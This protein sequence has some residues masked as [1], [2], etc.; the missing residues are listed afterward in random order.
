MAK[1]M[2]PLIPLLGLG[3]IAALL[4]S[5]KS[6]AAEVPPPA[7]P[8]TPPPA[9]SVGTLFSKNGHTWK[10]IPLS[11]GQTDVFAP[12]GSWGP[13]GEL[14]VLRFK[15]GS[16]RT[17]TGKAD[18]VPKATFDAA[19]KDLGVKIASA[20]PTV[21]TPP[22][23]P[24]M[25]VA[26][27]QEMIALGLELGVDSNGVVRGPVK[28]SGVQHATEL[29]SRLEQAGYPEAA[30]VVR[31]QATD[32]AKMV[33]LA[34]PAV[35]LPGVPPEIQAA[36]ARALQLERDPAKLE[37]LK[38]SLKTLPASA[39]R[40]MLIG[41]LDAM[42]LQIRTAQAV[43]TAAT[44]IDQ[45]TRAPAAGSPQPATGPRLLK[46]T[47]PNMKGEDVRAWQNV[48]VAS[49]YPIKA[50]GIFGPKTS[51]A[52]KDWQKRHALKVD[53]IVGP[54]TRAK[55]GTPPTAAAP[56]TVPATASPRPD[57]KPKSAREIAAEAMVTH[58]LALQGKHGVKGSKGKQDLTIVKRFQT[59]VNGVADGLPG[60]NTMIAAARAGQGRLPKVMYWSKS[61][62]KARDLPAYRAQLQALAETAASAGL[63][64]LASQL[65]QSAAAEDGSGGL[66]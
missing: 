64:T 19:M 37:A 5:S 46:L 30:A 21:M 15:E 34:P 52:T 25:P 6:E 35:T 3:G 53:G 59:S 47:T 57:P 61:A 22:G 9:G 2:S 51:D 49:G 60:V 29:A 7:L 39:E 44:E 42:I 14:R 63:H 31:K 32:A 23:R 50:D 45:A 58:L 48:L 28:A 56:A 26:L 12:A 66:T 27:Q 33:P 18:G 43:S 62:T 24:P 13:H 55:I 40:D 10:L 11:G 38:Q 8:A 17:L 4:L 54:K 16:P 65:V 36:I 41:A 20:A 1:K